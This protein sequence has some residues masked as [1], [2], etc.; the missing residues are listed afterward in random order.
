MS[1]ITNSTT[2]V[3]SRFTSQAHYQLLLIA[4]GAITLAISAQISI[5]WQ[6]VPLTF[7]SSTVVLLGLVF[8]YRMGFKMV[9]TYLGVGA[10][11]IPVFADFSAGFQVFQG[12]TAGYL[13]GF[14]PAVAVAGYL[15]QCGFAKN[16]LLSFIAALLAVSFIFMFGVIGL[17]FFIGWKNAILVGVMPFVITETVKLFV[18]GICT[19]F[20]W[21]KNSS[22]NV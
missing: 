2:N 19:P 12:P 5:P 1:T 10:L 11:G 14:L 13:M 16:W 22:K 20:F 7:Q 8:G 6:P 4:I 21:K 18:A 15:A 17:H 3:F 9:L